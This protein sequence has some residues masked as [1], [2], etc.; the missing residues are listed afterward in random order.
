GHH[1]R[2]RPAAATEGEAD[3]R[4]QDD[5]LV[6]PTI[7]GERVGRAD[8]V[9]VTALA[10]DR[11]PGMLGDG[12]VA[13]QLDRAA[14]GERGQHGGDGAAR[15]PAGGPAAM[16]RGGVIAAGVARGQGAQA[17]E[18]AGD[19]AAAGGEDGGQGQQDEALRGRSG[20]GLLQRLED[21]ADRL[22]EPAAGPL[23]L[24]AAQAGLAGRPAAPLPPEPALPAPAGAGGRG[25]AG[26]GGGG[27][28]P[29]GAR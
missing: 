16:G 22:G 27:G 15:G 29:A 9:A 25:A 18:Q 8:R 7:G 24:A 11:V 28:G 20:E 17:A 5:P 12:V 23:E 4:R 3:Q 10:V 6:P 14:G 1:Q 26:G 19:G 13:R 2:Q 21:G